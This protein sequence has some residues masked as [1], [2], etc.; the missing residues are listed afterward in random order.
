VQDRLDAWLGSPS[1]FLLVFTWTALI[2]VMARAD[3]LAE[4]LQ[5]FSTMKEEGTS[6]NQ[7]TFTTVMRAHH[8]QK[9]LAGLQKSLQLFTDA[10][11]TLAAASDSA[12]SAGV[13]PMSEEQLPM[14][15]EMLDGCRSLARHY[16]TGSSSNK[17]AVQ[18]HAG[19]VDV[20]SV[21]LGH[22]LLDCWTDEGKDP[23]LEHL[24]HV[25]IQ[26][27]L[28]CAPSAT[29]KAVNGW[30]VRGLLSETDQQLLRSLQTNESNELRSPTLF[31]PA[32]RTKPGVSGSAKC[33]HKVVDR[34]GRVSFGCL[35]PSCPPGTRREL[36]RQ[37]LKALVQ[38]LSGVDP[39][40]SK[41]PVSARPSVGLGV[42]DFETLMHQCRKRKWLQELD[43]V[44]E[45]MV[46]VA[47][48]GKPELDPPIPPHPELRPGW[49]THECLLEARL[50][51]G[52]LDAAHASYSELLSIL[53]GKSTPPRGVD[54]AA[55]PQHLDNEVHHVRRKAART[56]VAV[57]QRLAHTQA[58]EA[59]NKGEAGT[60]NGV[61]SCPEFIVQV[62][63]DMREHRVWA[64][65]QRLEEQQ[66]GQQRKGMQ[67]RGGGEQQIGEQQDVIL[68]GEGGN[69]TAVVAAGEASG[70]LYSRRFKSCRRQQHSS[71]WDVLALVARSMGCAYKH[72][73]L[74]LK[75]LDAA[76]VSW[77]GVAA[78]EAAAWHQRVGELYRELL[79]AVAESDPSNLGHVTEALAMAKAHQ[80]DALDGRRKQA[81]EPTGNAVK[82]A[83]VLRRSA[84]ALVSC[85]IAASSES[86]PGMMGVTEY[87]SGHLGLVIG[88]AVGTSSFG[89][90]SPAC[91]IVEE[92][93]LY[94]IAAE[95]CHMCQIRRT[96]KKS[97]MKQ[98]QDRKQH[99]VQGCLAAREQWL[100]LLL[101][102]APF[103]A[104][105]GDA[106][107]WISEQDAPKRDPQTCA[108]SEGRSNVCFRALTLERLCD[109]ATRRRR[110]CDEQENEQGGKQKMTNPRNALDTVLCLLLMHVSWQSLAAVESKQ[111]Q[112][113][114]LEQINRVLLV[115]VATQYNCKMQQQ[116]T[117]EQLML[118]LSLDCVSLIHHLR[119]SS[120]CQARLV[121][122]LLDAASFGVASR[123]DES[124]G[125][126]SQEEYL[127]LQQHALPFCTAF[128][129]LKTIRGGAPTTPAGPDVAAAHAVAAAG[130]NRV[131][132][133]FCIGD[134]RLLAVPTRPPPL[135]VVAVFAQ[136]AATNLAHGCVGVGARV[137][138]QWAVGKLVY[139]LQAKRAGEGKLC[140]RESLF[141]E[142]KNGG[143]EGSSG[144]KS[145]EGANMGILFSEAVE[146]PLRVVNLVAN[147]PTVRECC[148]EFCRP[149]HLATDMSNGSAETTYPNAPVVALL[150]D[151]MSLYSDPA[152]P[153]TFVQGTCNQS[154]EWQRLLL[155]GLH[156]G[157]MLREAARCI[158]RFDLRVQEEGP[159]PIVA[160]SAK[161]GG[162]KKGGVERKDESSEPH[163]AAAD[164]QGSGA[165]V[166]DSTNTNEL[167]LGVIR[168]YEVLVE[169]EEQE[170]QQQRTAAMEVAAVAVVVAMAAANAAVRAKAMAMT[171]AGV[172]MAGEWGAAQDEE[173]DGETGEKG[174]EGGSDTGGSDT[175]GAD[176]GGQFLELEVPTAWV[177]CIESLDQASAM[178]KA[179]VVAA[180]AAS[181]V[182]MSAVGMSAPG[183]VSSG[184]SCCW[185]CLNRFAIGLDVEWRPDSLK[186]G[187]VTAAGGKQ[188]RLLRNLASIRSSGG[189]SGGGSGGGSSGSGGSG[190]C[191]TTQSLCSILQL[192]C[193]ERVYVFDLIGLCGVESSQ[194][195]RG[196]VDDLLLFL[197]RSP[198]V[199]KLGF[200][201]AHDLHRL[202]VSFPTMTCFQPDFVPELFLLDMGGVQ[203]TGHGM[204][205][206]S[207]ERGLG[208]IKRMAGTTKSYSLSK[209]VARSCGLGLDKT[210]QCSD[211]EQ[212][213]LSAA[214]LQY[215]ALDAWA[216]LLVLRNSSSNVHTCR[217]GGH[218]TV[219]KECTGTSAPSSPPCAVLPCTLG[220]RSD[221]RAMQD[222]RAVQT[223][224]RALGLDDTTF[225][226]VPDPS[227]AIPAP[228]PSTDLSGLVVCKTIALTVLVDAAPPSPSTFTSSA[229]ASAATA[230]TSVPPSLV[231]CVLGL[232]RRL[233]LPLV[234]R[235][236]G[237][238][239]GD[240]KFVPE[241]ELVDT[242]GYPKGGIGPVGL[243]QPATVVIDQELMNAQAL[244]CGAGT[245]G[246]S[247]GA[248]PGALVRALGARVASITTAAGGTGGGD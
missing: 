128:L 110:P 220:P 240:V 86:V 58:L 230:S 133:L 25:L 79:R 92:I 210:C 154:K 248:E 146:K 189:S 111:E 89:H 8:R 21:V 217:G 16:A 46:Q 232:H 169:T 145:S 4:A 234:A 5:L 98:K 159:H 62:V 202:H 102:L 64:S 39:L 69:V 131:L 151:L 218:M 60:E 158:C 183:A 2:D 33:V 244:H 90:D 54:M 136:H 114:L 139:A 94:S 121:R 176:Q 191:G 229:P 141:E 124:D 174:D 42:S 216:L 167:L 245:P 226:D 51:L 172:I 138:A 173:A 227:T 11:V 47:E 3:R 156:K 85:L 144:S 30:R 26:L 31:R 237:A 219:S 72:A 80:T 24:G 175:G 56:W 246:R 45:E 36:L 77:L 142:W 207:V 53:K 12:S 163:K 211:W 247:F 28:L 122:F 243:C 140:K 9:T 70:H 205:G 61:K 67:Q 107:S 143:Q 195:V 100:Q 108:S 73:L 35:G 235:L 112:A 208:Q 196:R 239:R 225:V 179:L 41:L 48:Y 224:L 214:Q 52:A 43:M 223:A 63:S 87:V 75:H 97:R 204:T 184:T 96:T 66:D 82:R 137:L 19:I 238:R 65:V 215:A 103:A 120:K 74:V 22:L 168:D 193:A 201:L 71:L 190:G 37:D 40:W 76:D 160:E 197:F 118:G 83:R 18:V 152:I 32:N 182:D 115:A 55:T 236:L 171:S 27:D 81:E 78:C 164:A 101:D 153:S 20:I 181:A 166:H 233:E 206:Q 148:S 117:Q 6:P 13:T 88:A 38:R 132:G 228:P 231:V 188:R 192:A 162:G 222:M 68:V 17:R 91:N 203:L 241:A 242:T 165:G 221:T 200:G 126:A 199:L 125:E 116:R 95:A 212:R 113:A 147:S 161:S 123:V 59:L 178:L 150:I 23:V 149:E 187:V 99:L 106:T 7:V 93:A 1:P 49:S 10:T 15:T 177:S 127:H 119:L 84:H 109:L 104:G 57:L 14:I 186:G 29:A 50:G 155:Q 130:H 135:E 170:Q 105:A 157:G 44:L 213:P 209:L 185:A 34:G 198:S 129:Q 180:E 134:E 194:L